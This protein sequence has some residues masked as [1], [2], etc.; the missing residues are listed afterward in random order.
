MIKK[1]LTKLIGLKKEDFDSF[2]QSGQ[3]IVQPARLIPTL[4]TGEEMALTSIFLSTARLVKEYRDGLFKEIKLSR[5][6]KV[7][8]YTEASFPDINKSRIEGLIIVVIKGV[9]NNV[10]M[11]LKKT[12]IICLNYEI[13]TFIF[14]I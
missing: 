11:D 8:F 9:L 10:V 4:K 1:S 3:I 14:F 2:I 6:G 13:L 7:Y 12:Q 5:S